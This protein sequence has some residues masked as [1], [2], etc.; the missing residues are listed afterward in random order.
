[1]VNNV[2]LKRLY[3]ALVLDWKR[4]IKYMA[5]KLFDSMMVYPNMVMVMVMVMVY[6]RGYA[7]NEKKNENEK[8]SV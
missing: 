5:N 3:S 2:F 4:I 1:M 6:L 8:L 7:A